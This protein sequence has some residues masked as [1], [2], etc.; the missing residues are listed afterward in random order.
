[1]TKIIYVFEDCCVKA[2]LT[3]VDEFVYCDSSLQLCCT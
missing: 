2:V 3:V 1:M